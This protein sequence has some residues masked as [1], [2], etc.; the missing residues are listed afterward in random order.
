MEDFNYVFAR[1]EKLGIVGDNGTGKSTFIK[2]LIGEI[3]P[4][5]GRFIIGDSIRFGYYSQDGLLFDEN[6]KVIDVVKNIAEYITL[7]NGKSL[8][9]S[10]FLSHFLF[11]PEKQYDFIHKLSGGEQRRLYLCT[12]LM[13]NPNFLVLDEPTNDLD[14]ATL[15]VL[16]EYLTD[17]KGCMIV[18]S[19]DRYFMDKIVDHLFVFHGN[20][21]IQNF[22]GNYTQYRLW[23]TQQTKTVNSEPTNIPSGKQN[24]RQP[25]EKKRLTYKEQKELETLDLEIPVLEN[26]K[27]A[28]EEALHNSN[29]TFEELHEKSIRIGKLIHEIEEKTMRWFELN[30][31]CPA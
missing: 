28:L 11:P 22:P 14:I 16:E 15:N 3:L 1:Y 23:R 17:F 4:D 5:H 13:R 6:M 9:V 29:L 7:S 8:S 19:H 24:F 31:F 18:V 12:V 26:E 21:E 27:K 30:E 2:M 10:Q 25:S 20:A